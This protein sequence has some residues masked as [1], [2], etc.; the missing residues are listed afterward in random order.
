MQW[1]DWVVVVVPLLG[2]LGVAYYTQRFVRGVADY[3]S[4]G[5]CAGRYLLT[6]ASGEAGAG[7]TNTVGNVEK[8]MLTGFVALFWDSLITPILL[9]LAITGFVTYRYRQTRVLTLAQ[10]FNI[11]AVRIRDEHDDGTVR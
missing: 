7:V 10:F 1:I 9:I 8:Y 6:S 3:I 5:R 2:I 11:M 4:A